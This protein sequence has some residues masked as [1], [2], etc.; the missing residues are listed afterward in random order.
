MSQK[1]VSDFLKLFEGKN[2]SVLVY[3]NYGGSIPATEKTLI[4]IA[5]DEDEFW[6]K[7][8][9]VSKKQFTS[10]KNWT[11]TN[12]GQCKGVTDRGRGRRCRMGIKQHIHPKD[13]IEELADYCEHHERQAKRLRGES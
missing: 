1:T 2:V 3:D 9:G 11:K 7:Y 10:W 8:F 12:D 6:A 5:S 4:A 13:F